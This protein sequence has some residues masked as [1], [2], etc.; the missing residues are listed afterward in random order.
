M[1]VKKNRLNKDKA[2]RIFQFEHWLRFYFIEEE[3]KL[4][5]F[6][7]DEEFLN[8]LRINYSPLNEIAENLN[9]KYLSPEVSQKTIVEFLQKHFEQE[10]RDVVTP[11]LDSQ[12]FL[13]ELQLFNVWVSLFEDTLEKEILPFEKW[14]QIFEKWKSSEQAKKILYSLKMDKIEKPTSNEIN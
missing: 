5:T 8:E 10:D 2:V 6:N 4:L 9:G 11:I 12:P 7:F 1:K 3:G 13:R 14:V